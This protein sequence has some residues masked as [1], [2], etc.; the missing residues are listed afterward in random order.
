MTT[1]NQLPLLTTL[2]SGDQLVVWATGQ[3]DSRRVPVATFT[4]SVLASPALTGTVTL[5][6]DT[7]SLGAAD[8]GGTGFRLLRVPN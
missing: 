8:S 6:G 7:V 3:G 2:T 1:I 5:D 4:A